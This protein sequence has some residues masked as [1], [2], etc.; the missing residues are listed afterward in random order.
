M[1]IWVINSFP[2]MFEAYLDSGVAG[3]ALRGERGV[4]FDLRSVLLREFSPKDFKGVDDAPYGGGEG[5]VLRA[6][7]LKNAIEKGIVEPGGYGEDWRE[8]L[9]I[10]YTSP[11]GKVWKNEYAKDF[12]HRVWGAEPR[13]VVFI[14]GR[15]EGIDERFIETYVDEIIS[16]GDYVI[17]GGEVAVMTILDSALR[18]VPGVL[19]N[20]ISAVN[21]SFQSGLLEEPVYTRPREFEGKEVPEVLLSGNH[22]R[23]SEYKKEERVRITKK[24]RPDLLNE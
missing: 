14:C 6:D 3:Q 7:V 12:A 22:K 23:I 1:K 18:F 11:R 20:K 10:V 5:M 8:K 21:E 4:D 2:K 13:D 9:H 24:Y 16:L 15:Y 19:G 17:T